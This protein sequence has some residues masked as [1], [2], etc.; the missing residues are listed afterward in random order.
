MK[1]T[2]HASQDNRPKVPPLHKMFDQNIS[3]FIFILPMTLSNVFGTTTLLINLQ[4]LNYLVVVRCLFK[5]KSCSWCPFLNGRRKWEERLKV[6]CFHHDSNIISMITDL[7]YLHLDEC[8][9]VLCVCEGVAWV[10][11][12]LARSSGNALSME[13]LLKLWNVAQQSFSS[14]SPFSNTLWDWIF[15]THLYAI[16]T[17]RLPPPQPIPI[18]TLPFTLDLTIISF[19]LTFGS[20]TQRFIMKMSNFNPEF[21]L[22]SLI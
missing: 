16:R 20:K 14:I 17:F 3:K 11:C 4:E 1:W 2:K 15:F 18:W 6:W 8:L 19:S 9:Y 12:T 7:Q 21:T 5:K 13:A 10:M 22:V